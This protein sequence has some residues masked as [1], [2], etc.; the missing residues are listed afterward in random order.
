MTTSISSNDF[1]G[2][3][4]TPTAGEIRV[5]GRKTIWSKKSFSRPITVEAEMKPENGKSCINMQLFAK[6]KIRKY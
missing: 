6:N 3:Y 2:E 1:E 4:T 5:A